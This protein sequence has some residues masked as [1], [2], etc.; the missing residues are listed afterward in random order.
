MVDNGFDP[1][2]FHMFNDRYD[3]QEFLALIDKYA[4]RDDDSIPSVEVR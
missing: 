2:S 3:E 4:K 1:Y